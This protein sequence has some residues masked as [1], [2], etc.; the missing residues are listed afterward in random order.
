MSVHVKVHGLEE[1]RA[2][3][4]TRKVKEYFEMLS[5]QQKFP[6]YFKRLDD[7]GDVLIGKRFGPDLQ[8]V[9]LLLSLALHQPR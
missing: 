2:R 5:P 9:R 7:R 4:W 3:T 6:F 8:P 1:R